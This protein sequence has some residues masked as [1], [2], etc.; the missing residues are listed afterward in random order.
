[1][2]LSHVVKNKQSWVDL[3]FIDVVG[4]SSA[5]GVTYAPHYLIGGFATA[6]ASWSR[7]NIYYGFDHSR[8]FFSLSIFK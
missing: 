2:L 6:T 5:R 8:C 3:W 7:L 4:N 1:M